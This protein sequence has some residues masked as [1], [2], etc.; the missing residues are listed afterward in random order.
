MDT[1]GA[2]RRVTIKARH[3]AMT[4]DTL[5]GKAMPSNPILFCFWSHRGDRLRHRSLISSLPG[6]SVRERGVQIPS[7]APMD[8]R[9]IVLPF[10]LDSNVQRERPSQMSGA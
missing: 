9:A 6:R 10:L 8:Q 1:S 2:D 7:I 5:S 3:H 4:I